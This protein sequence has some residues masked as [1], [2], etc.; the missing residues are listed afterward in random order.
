[1]ATPAAL[2]NH[3]RRVG[4]AE[5]RSTASFA[6][7][8]G[9]K[10]L[11]GSFISMFPTLSRRPGRLVPAPRGAGATLYANPLLTACLGEMLPSHRQARLLVGFCRNV[12][13][14]EAR[15]RSRGLVPST[16]LRDWSRG[17]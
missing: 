15:G 13:S 8:I 6:G 3:C 16:C 9:R 5:G 7:F 4:N 10:T 14:S 12:A 2:L 11:L 1:M 17:E